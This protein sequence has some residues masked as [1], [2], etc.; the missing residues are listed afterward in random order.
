[1][2]RI[3]IQTFQQRRYT[4]GQQAREKMLNMIN[5]SASLVAQWYVI[6]L[7]I[8]LTPE[9]RRSPGEGNNN[10]LQYSSLG[11]PMDRGAWRATVHGVAKE[12]DVTQQLNQ[13]NHRL[14]EKHKSKLQCIIT[15]YQPECPSLKSLQIIYSG[16]SVKKRTPS[17]T[18]DWNVSWCNHYRKQHRNSSKH[19]KW[20]YH[21]IQE[22][23]FCVSIQR[24]QEHHLEKRYAPWC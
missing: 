6:H 15:S 19:V 24:N 14:L 23:H 17:W 10:P 21:M 12:P 8:V 13:Q 11:N 22:S 1:M 7:P 18:V 20:N 3:P 2:G 5:Y 4:D 16:Q 9:L